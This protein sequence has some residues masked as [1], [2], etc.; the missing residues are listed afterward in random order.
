MIYLAHGASGTAESM[1]LHVTGL[2]ERGL[3]AQAVGLPVGKAEKAVDAY[4]TQ[5]SDL[6]SAVIGGHSFGGRV[7]SLVAAQET[8]RALVLFSYPLHRPGRPEW[9][10]RTEHWA[11]INCPV[12]F[13][14]GERD[15]FANIELLRVAIGDRL[16]N[17]ELIT[18]PKIG[19]GLLR[20]LDDALDRV[21][22]FVRALETD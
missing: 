6:A 2:V 13:L 4:L 5:V 12:L 21:A 9:E 20:V 11:R 22:R 1:R 3:D 15:L 14:S 16:P 8:P 18:Y 7:A 19:H 17:A 10:A